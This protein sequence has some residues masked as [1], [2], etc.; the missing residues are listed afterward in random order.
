MLDAIFVR[1]SQLRAIHSRT[2]HPIPGGQTP[3]GPRTAG[4][5]NHSHGLQRAKAW[6]APLL[7]SPIQ[8]CHH[9]PR[10][11]IT[12]VQVGGYLRHTSRSNAMTGGVFR[13]TPTLAAWTARWNCSVG[14]LAALAG[15]R[16]SA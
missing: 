16:G 9:I 5:T 8:K 7:S 6:R 4:Y 13:M 12:K 11:A 2:M 15:A 10:R 14:A 3:E 1:S